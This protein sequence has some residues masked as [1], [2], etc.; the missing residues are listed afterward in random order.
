MVSM[1]SSGGLYFLTRLQASG[2][3]TVLLSVDVGLVSVQELRDAILLDGRRRN[4]HWRVVTE[5]GIV[6]IYREGTE[7]EMSRAGEDG[8]EGGKGGYKRPARF[9]ISFE[10]QEEARRFIRDWHRRPF[11]RAE[12]SSRGRGLGDDR[13]PIISAT[14]MW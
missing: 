8:R 3:G 14:I 9:V 5:E 2:E 12:K 13:D 4:L 10:D 1:L 6:P 11:R 7:E